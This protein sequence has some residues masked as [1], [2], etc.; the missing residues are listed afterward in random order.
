MAVSAD[1]AMEWKLGSV[2]PLIPGRLYF[3]VHSDDAHTARVIQRETGLFLFSSFEHEKYRPYC[4][5]FG[6]VDLESVVEFCRDVQTRMRDPRLTGRKLVY[7]CERD[8][9]MRTNAAFL[10]GAYLVL[11]AGWTAE[12]A[13]KTFDRI[14]PC[15]FMMFRDATDLRSDFDL[16]ILDCLKGL[17]KAK[18]PPEEL[19]HAPASI[20][21]AAGGLVA[22]EHAATS[23][24]PPLI[25]PD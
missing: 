7:Y 20:W 19:A 21:S 14:V 1:L 12:D 24:I 16:S 22:A 13:A 11:V 17:A 18:V 23:S 2:Y 9:A 15:P 10:L 5:D 6:P 8:R 3:T 4:S 25:Q